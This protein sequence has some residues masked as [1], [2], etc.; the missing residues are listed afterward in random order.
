MF[1]E[2]KYWYSR[3]LRGKHTLNDM[4]KTMCSEE[5]IEGH[6][7]NHSLRATGATKQLFERNVPKKV[8]Q[9][10]TEHRSVNRLRH[11]EKVVVKQKQAACN[12]LTS[13][14]TS[15]SFNQEVAQPI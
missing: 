7:T 1:A 5:D 6:F 9:E 10:F 8:I 4:V 15:G 11:Y 14:S 3:Q 2:S 13:P 12:I